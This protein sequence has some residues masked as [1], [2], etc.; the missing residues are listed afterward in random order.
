MKLISIVSLAI[1]ICQKLTRVTS[2]VH[3]ANLSS[4]SCLTKIKR[5]VRLRQWEGS[6]KQ[7]ITELF[8]NKQLNNSLHVEGVVAD[9]HHALA[10]VDC[11]GQ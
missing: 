3:E 4:Q 8:M 5:V 11:L 7:G 9:I 2:V 1:I 6:K 10:H